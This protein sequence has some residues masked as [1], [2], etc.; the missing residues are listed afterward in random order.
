D[1]PVSEKAWR[2]PPAVKGAPTSFLDLKGVAP[3][4]QE[5]VADPPTL[6]GARTREGEAPAE[7]RSSPVRQEPRPPD[8]RRALRRGTPKDGLAV[9]PPGADNTPGRP[10]PGAHNPMSRPRNLV[11]LH[12][13]QA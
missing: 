11:E 4:G 12:R 1:V 8:A 5:T 10:T 9:A 3:A 6:S 13:L 7:P 2:C